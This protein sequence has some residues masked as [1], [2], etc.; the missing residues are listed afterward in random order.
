MDWWT[1]TELTVIMVLDFW[2]PLLVLP[3]LSIPGSRTKSS[4]GLRS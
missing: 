1:A 3:H 4:P 2:V